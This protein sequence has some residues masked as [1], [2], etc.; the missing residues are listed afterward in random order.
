MLGNRDVDRM[1]LMFCPPD[2]FMENRN[3]YINRICDDNFWKMKLAKDYPL[4][5]KYV[6]NINTPKHLNISKANLYFKLARHKSRIFNLQY[7]RYIE[8]AEYMYRKKYGHPINIIYTDGNYEKLNKY[9]IETHPDILRGDVVMFNGDDYRNS[10]KFVW[11]GERLINLDWHG[12]DYGNAPE[13]ICFPEV[14]LDFFFSSISH[15]TYIYIS[16]E[17]AIEIIKTN[18][19]SDNYNY[20]KIQINSPLSPKKQLIGPK[21]GRNIPVEWI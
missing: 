7:N 21:E 3:P 13:E 10:G 14:P 2:F 17:K 5:S 15:N 12:D 20:Y 1:L 8:Y 6:Y 19:L 9:V 18:K 11:D 4:R 16:E